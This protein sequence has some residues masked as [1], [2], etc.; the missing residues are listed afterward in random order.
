MASLKAT[1]TQTFR[2]DRKHENHEEKRVQPLTPPKPERYSVKL[3]LQS[4]INWPQGEIL[5]WQIND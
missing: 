2:G 3:L 5:I 4:Q 1:A